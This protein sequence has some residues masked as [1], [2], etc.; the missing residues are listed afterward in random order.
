MS[1]LPPPLVS[2]EVDLRDFPF[3]PL[4]FRRLFS[5]DTWLIGK[6]EARCAAIC[7]WC[8]A[9]HG[10]PAASLSDNDDVLA[11]LSQSGS[12]WPK[13]KA[14]V[15]RG[16]VKCSDGRLYHPVVAEKALEAWAKHRKAS[17]KGKAGAAKRWG[18]A[19]ASAN[20]TGIATANSTGNSTGISAG[21]E[22]LMPNDSNRSG[23][24]SGSEM[25]RN[26]NQL[27]LQKPAQPDGLQQPSPFDRGIVFM[28]SKGLQR[29]RINRFLA[30]Q[31]K[32]FGDEAT[33]VALDDAIAADV[34][35]PIAWLVAALK[36][37]PNGRQG[38][39]GQSNLVSIKSAPSPSLRALMAMEENKRE[40]GT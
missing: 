22:Q 19:N 33:L 10:T 13:I 9:W 12:R 2:P 23:S 35:E 6:A 8:E 18:T 4:E 27:Q 30:M 14:H 25:N 26:I 28:V 17:S 15:L 1:N 24:R 5:S 34:S 37:M 20:S 7:L 40:I 31:R 21:I 39:S 11:Q 32:N 36:R 16:W 29:D 3:F 38:M